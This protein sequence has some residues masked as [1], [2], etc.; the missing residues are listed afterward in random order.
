MS[1]TTVERRD[2]DDTS[3]MILR[4]AD[5][6]ID[7]AIKSIREISN[8]LS[9]HILNNFGLKKATRNF[10]N[11]INQTN[12]I[13]IDFS[14]N[15]NEQRFESDV[16]VVIYRVICELITNTIKHAKANT[17]EISLVLVGK[18]LHGTY[19][20]DGIGFSPVDSTKQNPTGMGFSNILSRVKSLNGTFEYN[21]EIGKGFTASFTIPI[22]P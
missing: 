22:V 13:L 15:I 17:V 16:E 12:A 8:N 10:I 21:S 5:N 20:D 18:R 9:P 2:Y 14:T 7:E 4:N 19:Q 1:L 11:K 6:A 3:K